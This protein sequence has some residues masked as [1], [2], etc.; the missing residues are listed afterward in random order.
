MKQ[1]IRDHTTNIRT[2]QKDIDARRLAMTVQ[3]NFSS[4]FGI[5][6][7][8]LRGQEVLKEKIESLIDFQEFSILKNTEEIVKTA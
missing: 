5:R 2:Y 7:L 3:E 8:E 4:Y 6:F 1:Y